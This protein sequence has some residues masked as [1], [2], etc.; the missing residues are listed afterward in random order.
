MNARRYEQA[1]E[2][3]RSRFQQLKAL[4][5]ISRQLTAT[6]YLHNILGFA[7]EEA[8]RATPATQGIS[9]YVAM[10]RCTRAA[11]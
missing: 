5:R 1:D 4:Q 8:L 9:L 2:H 7:L 6:L 3:L 10:L 11:R